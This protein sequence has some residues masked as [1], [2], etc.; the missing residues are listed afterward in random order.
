[1]IQKM[2]VEVCVCEVADGII[3]PDRP[4]LIEGQRGQ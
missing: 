2:E 4:H 3:S 1:M